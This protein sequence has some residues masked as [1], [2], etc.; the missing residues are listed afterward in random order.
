MEE[1]MRLFHAVPAA[2]RDKALSVCRAVLS[3]LAEDEDQTQPEAR[4]AWQF[5]SSWPFRHRGR[6]GQR[7]R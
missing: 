7:R 4:R 3:A 6:A 5:L 2:R 1:V